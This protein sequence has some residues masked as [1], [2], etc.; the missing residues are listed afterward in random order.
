MKKRLFRQAIIFLALGGVAAAVVVFLST[1]PVTVEVAYPLLDVPVKVF[2]L[3]TVEARVLSKVGFE[4]GAALVELNTDHG[5]RIRTGEVLARLHSAEQE[6]RV[7]RAEA[8]LVNAEAALRKANALVAEAQAVLAQRKQTN[9]RQQALLAKRS[10]SEEVAEEAQMEQEIAASGL[11]VAQSGVAVAKAAV[12]DAKAQYAY[13]NVLLD[14]HVL[15]A[16]YDALVVERHKELGAV[17]TPGE[18]L[19]TLIDP[20]TVWVLGYVDESRAGDIRVGQAAEVRLRSLPRES[21]PGHVVRIGIE[22][23]R[24]SEERRVYVACDQCP[25]QFHIG[26]QAEILVTTARLK[27]TLLVPESAVESFD[28]IQGT[29]WTVEDG[30]LKRRTVEFGHRTLDAQLEIT[31]GLVPGVEVVSKLRSGLREGRAASVRKE[32]TS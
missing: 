31:G 7:A 11:A 21:F 20:T 15:R 6:A 14:H 4:V 22:S 10:V 32:A 13:E 1:R 5:D 28:G 16:P 30:R 24:V 25:E 8:G 9:R 27:Q 3:G 26:E 29:V 23:D 17:L 19:F 2:G 18:P 12:E